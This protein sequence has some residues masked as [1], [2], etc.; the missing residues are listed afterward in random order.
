MRTKSIQWDS[1]WPK[2]IKQDKRFELL[3]YWENRFG[4]PPSLFAP[5]EMAASSRVTYLIR[6]SPHIKGLASTRIVRA[7][8]PFMRNTGIHLKPTTEAVQLFGCMATR[9]RITLSREKLKK[10]C[11]NG[12][13]KLVIDTSPGFVFISQGDNLWGCGLFLP[14]ERLLCRLPKTITKE[15]AG[16][17]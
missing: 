10:L 8:I 9:N 16:F 4:V 13:T 2:Y 17:K 1:S 11:K 15:L 7:G 6:K 12:E 3:Q 5:F 14:P